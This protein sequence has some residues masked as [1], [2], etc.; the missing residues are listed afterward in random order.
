MGMY[1]TFGIQCRV[2]GVT[3]SDVRNKM[4]ELPYLRWYTKDVRMVLGNILV[5]EGNEI[6]IKNYENDIEN[7]MHWLIPFVD[8]VNDKRIIAVQWYETKPLPKVYYADG[9]CIDLSREIG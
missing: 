1:T 7:F 4:A 8:E 3:L 9:E 2:K 5:S 6:D